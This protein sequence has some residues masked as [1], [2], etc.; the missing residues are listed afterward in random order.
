MKNVLTVLITM[1]ATG[2]VHMGSTGDSVANRA[3]SALE[4]GSLEAASP[5]EQP[6][7]SALD[8]STLLTLG[9]EYGNQ[10]DRFDI[11]AVDIPAKDFFMSL[12]SNT[13]KNMVVP[14]SISGRITLSLKNVSVDEVLN[15]VAD[16]Y[17][18]DF[19][20]N[21]Y[22]Y[23]IFADELQTRVF[24]VDY[25]AVQRMGESRSQ[26]HAGDISPNSISEN[27]NARA[28]TG[29]SIGN[30]DIKTSS[31]SD[32][33]GELEAS[34]SNIIVGKPGRNISVSPQSSVVIA[35][36]SVRELRK[37]KQVLQA[38]EASV[39]R[40]VILEAKILEVTLSEGFQ[41]GINWSGLALNGNG[42]GYTF[43]QV[44]S[45]AFGS[46][47][48]N[49]RGNAGSVT[50]DG[51]GFPSLN[52]V[53]AFGGAFNLAFQSD[54][55]GGFIELLKRQGDVQVLSSPRV[56][57]L[58]NQKAVIKVGT[59][60]FFVTDISTTTTSTAGSSTSSP[61]V[62]LTPFFSGIALD[63]T[64]QISANNIVTLHVHPTISEVSEASKFLPLGSASEEVP[65]AR[66]NVRESDSVI[67]AKS[68]EVVV[69]GGLM[70]SVNDNEKIGIPGMSD[71]PI[72]GHAFGQRRASSVKK[73]LV[74]LLRPVIVEDGEWGKVPQT[75]G[76]QG[77]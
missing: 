59:D 54:K 17:G 8:L 65:L 77:W 47:A 31:D 63:V 21:N 52:D 68:G 28:F 29:D 72:V 22:G 12:V 25:L 67:R 42:N 40:Q 53:A 7:V 15:A 48:A 11:N 9:D 13:P 37:I 6:P 74:I 24:E 41:S 18:Y 26:V 14:S 75:L 56:S 43:N 38:M 23:R 20:E 58:N 10:I 76:L 44:G 46:S 60:E 55:L 30:V 36:A 16:V 57:T 33:W 51:S 39:S 32:F 4:F 73:E 19:E 62:A 35:T 69:I 49:T 66:A 50:P 64:P 1:L 70:Q 45:G 2:C 71:A 61:S 3:Q 27:T 5:P 34:L